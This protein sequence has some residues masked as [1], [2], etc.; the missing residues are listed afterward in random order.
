MISEVS[1]SLMMHQNILVLNLSNNGLSSSAFLS[2]LPNLTF[3]NVSNNELEELDSIS[4]CV[5]LEEIV[6]SHNKISRVPNLLRMKNLSLIDAAFNLIHSYENVALLSQS[7]K[8]KVINLTQNPIA[9]KF[10]YKGVLKKLLPQVLAFDI[11]IT[12]SSLFMPDHD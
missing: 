4:H 9:N 5:K 3:V 11:S 12:V 10:N 7:R 1:L 6:F 8:L 2:K